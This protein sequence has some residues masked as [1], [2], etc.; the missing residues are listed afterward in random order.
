MINARFTLFIAFSFLRYQGR[1]HKAVAVG[2]M[3]GPAVGGYHYPIRSVIF[4]SGQA[5]RNAFWSHAV[6][7]HISRSRFG[8]Y[9]IKVFVVLGAALK[10]LSQDRIVLVS[11]AYEN[12]R[13]AGDRLA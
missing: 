5:Y 9:D 13:S 6:D 7:Q 1:R 3:G 8:W 4:S 10:V 2:E 12:H 11:G